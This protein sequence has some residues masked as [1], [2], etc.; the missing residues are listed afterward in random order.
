[1]TAIFSKESM[2]NHLND[3]QKAT[4]R[5]F[6]SMAENSLVL[7]IGYFR[8]MDH[9]GHITQQLPDHAF[10]SLTPIMRILL[11]II[12]SLKVCFS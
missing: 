10:G 5:A 9:L 4:V 7:T 12:V 11:R 8:F 6:E 2:E 1:M 3:E